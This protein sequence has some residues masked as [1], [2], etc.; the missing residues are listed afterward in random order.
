[1]GSQG[2][3]VIMKG[4]AHRHRNSDK[5]FY[6]YNTHLRAVIDLDEATLESCGHALSSVDLPGTFLASG[7]SLYSIMFSR[8]LFVLLVEATVHVMSLVKKTFA[9]PGATAT[10]PSGAVMLSSALIRH[11]RTLIQ[12]LRESLGGAATLED[13][14]QNVLTSGDHAAVPLVLFSVDHI[15]SSCLCYILET[16]SSEADYSADLVHGCPRTPQYRLLSQFSITCKVIE[17]LVLLGRAAC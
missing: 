2:A 7:L 3:R 1:M 15:I 17:E 11:L 10:L 6:Q 4:H 14:L 12:H 13:Q 9:A 5:D 16:K 8:G